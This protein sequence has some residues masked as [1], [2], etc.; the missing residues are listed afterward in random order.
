[1]LDAKGTDNTGI[2]IGSNIFIGRNTIFSCKNGDIELKDNVNIGFNSYIFSAN[3]VTVGKYGLI[4]AYCYLIGGGHDYEDKESPILEQ[5]RTSYGI[6]LEDNVW[7][8][9]GVKVQDGIR[10][11]ANSIIGTSAVVTKDIPPYSIA[12]GIP[13]RVVKKRGDQT[14]DP[15]PKTQD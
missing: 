2:T 1:M 14:Q 6:E 4:A 5:G 10:I 8:G 3:K 12:A 11:G 13:A 15:R 9:A 7:F